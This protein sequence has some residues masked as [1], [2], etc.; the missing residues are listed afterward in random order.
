MQSEISERHMATSSS[1]GT[2]IKPSEVR[3]SDFLCRAELV[4]GRV[5]NLSL[6]PGGSY[7]R[8]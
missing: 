7:F 3:L 4:L 8:V 2:Q 1:L 6:T 5:F